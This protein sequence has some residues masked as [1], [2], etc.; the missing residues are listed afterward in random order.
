MRNQ[1]WEKIG[2]ATII[3]QPI[4]T[5]YFS[6]TGR[7]DIFSGS[8]I[9]FLKEG[10]WYS[11]REEAAWPFLFLNNND[12]VICTLAF[13][14]PY[15]F[16]CQSPT[17]VLKTRIVCS[18]W[19]GDHCSRKW[20]GIYKAVALVRSGSKMPRC[21]YQITSIFLVH[22]NA[23]WVLATIHNLRRTS[24]FGKYTIVYIFLLRIT[25]LNQQT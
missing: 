2:Y 9:F 20:M 24:W 4:C 12:P 15:F 17:H 10:H 18:D 13:C 8:G 22:C 7:P 19:L 14:T 16:Q 5:H 6:L 3:A 23:F 21:Q 1:P 25:T 11:K